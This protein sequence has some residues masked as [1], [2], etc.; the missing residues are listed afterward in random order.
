MQCVFLPLSLSLPHKG[1]GNDVAL[2][3]S[4]AFARPSIEIKI[5]RGGFVASMRR[6]RTSGGAA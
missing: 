6:V 5:Y 4:P 2:L 1:G 3:C